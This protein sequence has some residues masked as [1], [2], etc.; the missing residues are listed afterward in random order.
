LLYG[1]EL[2]WDIVF[3]IVQGVRRKFLYNTEGIKTDNEKSYN[4]G[5]ITNLNDFIKL[6]QEFPIQCGNYNSMVNEFVKAV[7]ERVYGEGLTLELLI[8]LIERCKPKYFLNPFETS[9]LTV[10]K[11]FIPDF[12]SILQ[13]VYKD[14][15]KEHIIMSPAS[16]HRYKCDEDNEIIQSI[17]T[18]YTNVILVC[19]EEG[20]ER[21]QLINV[22]SSLIHGRV[23]TFIEVN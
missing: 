8:P 7:Y 18:R 21:Q 13:L 23:V 14:I 1:I 4:T 3:P 11:Q 2:S 6:E 16:E 15:E 19:Y 9:L 20:N 22:I 10:P 5:A 12:L 17:I